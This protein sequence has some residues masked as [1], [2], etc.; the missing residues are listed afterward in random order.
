MDGLLWRSGFPEHMIEELHGSAYTEHCPFCYK[1]YRR[2][3]E[4]ERGSPGH[5]TGNKCDFCVNKLMN[6]IVNFNDNYRNPLK[7]SIVDFH[8][9][10][11][12]LVI[13]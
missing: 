7:G 13:V 3:K 1:Y 8:S 4:V 9:N 5:L 6:T 12:D 10:K 2:L 11:V